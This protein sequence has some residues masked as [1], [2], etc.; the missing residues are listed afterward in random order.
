[1]K[2]IKI[3]DDLK[4]NIEMIYSLERKNNQ[5]KIDDWINEYNE[6]IKEFSDNPPEL[7]IDDIKVYK[8]EFNKQNSKEDLDKYMKALDSY[9][10]S[11]I[12]KKP[13][14]KETY[15]VILITGLKINI[16][17]PIYDKID[18]YLEQFIIQ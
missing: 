18:Q 11:I 12:G 6:Y 16:D 13:K 10:I 5:Y 17:Q 2:I 4:I 1:M 9:I 3:N 14:Y 8:P 15:S 7:M